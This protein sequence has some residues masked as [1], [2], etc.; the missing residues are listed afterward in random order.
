MF[1]HCQKRNP[2]DAD[3]LFI[4][5]GA[6]AKPFVGGEAT[7][8]DA[9]HLMEIGMVGA[10]LVVSPDI[11]AKVGK[12]SDCYRDADFFFNFARE[13]FMEGFAVVLSPAGK[14][15]KDT[16]GIT[17][18]NDEEFVIFNNKSACSSANMGHYF[19][20]NEVWA[21]EQDSSVPNGGIKKVYWRFH[22]FT[23]GC[24]SG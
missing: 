17:H 14:D 21:K 11:L 2:F 19:R 8:K 16:A 18:F 10:E 9:F 3:L 4:V 24:G 12:G 1:R 20:E 6:A 15:V 23:Q 7:M 13:A 5:F 22:G